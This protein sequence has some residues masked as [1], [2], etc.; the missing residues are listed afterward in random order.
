MRFSFYHIPTTAR[1]RALSPKSTAGP[2]WAWS[3]RSAV[4][5]KVPS[6]PR[7]WP[8][9]SRGW[10]L[11]R[12]RYSAGFEA[13]RPSVG[14]KG[15]AAVAGRKAAA[16]V[17]LCRTG[18]G[19]AGDGDRRGGGDGPGGGPSDDGR[20]A[21]VRSGPFRPNAARERPAPG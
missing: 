7:S 8:W 16:R 11:G 17:G 21:F 5:E 2:A 3:K 15:T 12:H 13:M 19:S 1:K 18:R 6:S 4:N 10:T 9:P 14:V 20:S